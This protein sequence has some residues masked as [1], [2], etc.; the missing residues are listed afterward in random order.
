MSGS[1]LFARCPFWWI[2]N[3]VHVQCRLTTG[4]AGSHEAGPPD[5][6]HSVGWNRTDPPTK[7]EPRR[8]VLC[9]YIERHPGETAP[10]FEGWAWIKFEMGHSSGPFVA[11]LPVE[12]LRVVPEGEAT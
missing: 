1:E 12:E 8:W 3:G 4:H 2:A 7:D 11:L 6:A 9:S 10:T 5:L